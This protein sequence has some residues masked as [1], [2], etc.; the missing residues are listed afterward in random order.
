MS[1]DS[2]DTI[3]PVKP[4]PLATQTAEP[5]SSRDFFKIASISTAIGL[6]CAAAS[7]ESL[8][9]SPVGFSFQ[10]TA[11]TFVAFA[12]GAAIGFFYWKLIAKSTTAAR[13]GSVLL[14]LAGI[15][16]F[17]YPLRFVPSGT[18]P[19]LTI[20]LLIATGALGTV[21]FIIWR[22]A[23]FLDADAQRGGVLPDS[24]PEPNHSGD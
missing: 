8:R 14:G 4:A 1:L 15:G 3:Q 11:G 19:D 24:Q 17:L 18:L 22:I 7:T 2:I 6:G 13:I 21:G 5:K 23:R 20:G 9:S 10:I 12:V 16:L